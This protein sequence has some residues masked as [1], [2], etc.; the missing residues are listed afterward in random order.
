MH[1]KKEDSNLITQALIWISF[2]AF[3][4]WCGYKNGI[5]TGTIKERARRDEEERKRYGPEAIRAETR[6][7][8]IDQLNR[9]N[10]RY[11]KD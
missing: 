2:A 1:Y 6:N 9:F 4:Y 3:G 8:M 5:L 7:K 11:G 10:I